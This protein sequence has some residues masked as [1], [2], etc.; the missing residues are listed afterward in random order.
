[1]EITSLFLIFLLDGGLCFH[2]I[3]ILTPDGSNVIDYDSDRLQMKVIRQHL[4]NLRNF[5]CFTTQSC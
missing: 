4:V 1:M 2:Y 5:V 3:F